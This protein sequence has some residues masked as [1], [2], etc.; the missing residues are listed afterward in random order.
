MPRARRQKGLVIA[1]TLAL[2][3]AVSGGAVAVAAG[4]GGNESSDPKFAPR[5]KITNPY[6][7]LSD[8]RECV[9]EG[10]KGATALR[11]VATRMDGTKRISWEDGSVDATV[12]RFRAYENGQL[13]EQA[14]D[15]F[16]QSTTGAVHYLGE[17]V[18]NYEN[19]QVANHDGTWRLGR[20]TQEPGVV[21]PAGPKAGVWFRAE[22]APPITAE[23]DV[24]VEE[25][26][27]LKVAAGTFRDVIKVR[28]I[29]APTGAVEYKYF[30]PGTGEIRVESPGENEVIELT[31]CSK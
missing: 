1:A 29:L 14:I 25:G 4:G 19:G 11:I 28:E 16:A 22:D 24:V 12:S 3:V 27:T 23:Q 2:M 6:L 31:G 7:P 20:D 21:M 30:A 15:Y 18:D 5:T 9:Y 26:L 13:A 17:D 8:S 10:K